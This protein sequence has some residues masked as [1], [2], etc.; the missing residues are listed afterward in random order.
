[1]R[2]DEKGYIVVETIGS[3]MLFTLLLVS[4][5]S[6]INVITVQQRVHYAMTQAAKELSMYSYIVEAFKLTDFMSSIN[7]SELERV[8][9]VINDITN[10]ATAVSTGDYGSAYDSA[11]NLSNTISGVMDDPMEAFLELVRGGL[12]FGKNW[13]VQETVI[14]P[15]LKKHLEINANGVDADRYLRTYK[16]NGG[17]DGINLIESEFINEDL[18]IIIVAKYEIDYFF[19]ALPL[20]FTKL[21]ITQT[22][23]TAAW[24]GGASND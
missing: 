7:T 10:T 4:I 20:P 8:F 6:L 2:K 22:A 16:V 23:K 18:D 21:S 9:S 17:L 12:G 3:F 24:L 14:R 1:M 5:I 11:E 13:I 19:G 15:M